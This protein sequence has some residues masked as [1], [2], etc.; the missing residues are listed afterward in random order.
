MCVSLARESPNSLVIRSVK[1]YFRQYPGPNRGGS[2]GA[3]ANA[4]YTLQTGD[5]SVS[6]QTDSEGAVIVGIPAGQTVN[7]Q[8]FGTTYALSLQD[9]IEAHTTV[10]GAIKRLV[11]LGYRGGS[12][13]AS[14]T[15]RADYALL[16]YQAD[17][18]LGVRG[19]DNGG[20]VPTDTQN[21]LRSVVGE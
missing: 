13:S 9:S 5:T 2:A 7:L 15:V 12:T 21:S 10:V 14:P 18:D 8:I 11:M 6:G 3:I 20:V 16:D 4:T 1:I 19:F 17:H